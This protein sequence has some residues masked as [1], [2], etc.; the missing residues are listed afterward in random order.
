MSSIGWIISSTLGI[1]EVLNFKI[2]NAISKDAK[3]MRKFQTKY[4]IIL[5]QNQKCL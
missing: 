2:N 4:S 1:D 5:D 3:L